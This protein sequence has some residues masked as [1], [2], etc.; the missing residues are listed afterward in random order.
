MGLYAAAAKMA[1][2]LTLLSGAFQVAWGPFSLS[3]YREPD[4]GQTFNWVLKSFVVIVCLTV[5]TVTLFAENLLNLLV[6]ERYAGG[7]ILVFPLLMGLAIQA[8]SWITEIGIGLSKRSY[9]SL[10]AYLAAIISTAVGIKLLTPEFGLIGVGLGALLGQIA[11]ALIASW[12]AQQA[13]PLPWD[14]APVVLVLLVT[15]IG[16][17]VAVWLR[18]SQ[19]II[20]SNIALGLSSLSVLGIGWM[21]VL[22]RDDRARLRKYIFARPQL[23]K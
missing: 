15:L 19:S 23:G 18:I 4:A 8:T 14:Y 2:L 16:G 3:V 13:H 17:L 10:S 12:L 21:I 20:L 7:A 11:K 1:M 9:L 5:L 6:T 22:K